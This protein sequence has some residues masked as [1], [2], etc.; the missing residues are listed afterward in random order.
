MKHLTESE[1]AERY[2]ALMCKAMSDWTDVDHHDHHAITG[3][4]MRRVYVCLRPECAMSW[5]VL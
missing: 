2:N 3:W 1:R 5:K 4:W